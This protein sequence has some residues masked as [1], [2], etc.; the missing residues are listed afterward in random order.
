MID[1]GGWHGNADVDVNDKATNDHN[2]DNSDV[3][4]FR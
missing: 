3:Y 4:C 2:D 1:S